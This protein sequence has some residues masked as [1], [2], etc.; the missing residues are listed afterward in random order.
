MD[1]INKKDSVII[2]YQFW[3]AIRKLV[4][5]A[6]LESEYVFKMHTAGLNA[7]QDDAAIMA[8]ARWPCDLLD[9]RYV[10]RH[11]SKLFTVKP[12]LIICIHKTTRRSLQDICLTVS[13]SDCPI[14]AQDAQLHQR[15]CVLR[16]RL[17]PASRWTVNRNKFIIVRQSDFIYC[18]SA[19]KISVKTVSKYVL[20]SG[21]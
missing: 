6:M 13:V 10:L 4:S 8:A 18:E 5:N 21:A 1:T 16:R 11:A 3:T 14:C 12:R 19:T 9:S 2:A 20:Q 15:F 17:L 7:C